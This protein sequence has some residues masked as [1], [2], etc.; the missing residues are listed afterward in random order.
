LLGK[1][2]KVSVLPLNT[3]LGL[4]ERSPSLSLG[5]YYLLV[6]LIKIYL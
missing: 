1:K 2:H 6:W 5:V 3:N 4:G